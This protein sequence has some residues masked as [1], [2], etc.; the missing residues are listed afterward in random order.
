MYKNNNGDKNKKDN[1]FKDK[2]ET[3]MMRNDEVLENKRNT[4]INYKKASKED[5]L[6]AIEKC[7]KKHEKTMKLLAK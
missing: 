3:N 1:N 4:N 7:H 6:K 2:G 5:V